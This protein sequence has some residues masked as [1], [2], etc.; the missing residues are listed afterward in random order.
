MVEFLRK[1]ESRGEKIAGVY[2]IGITKS[3]ILYGDGIRCDDAI[4]KLTA[5]AQCIHREVYD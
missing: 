2:S 1:S 4:I 5:R 3:I